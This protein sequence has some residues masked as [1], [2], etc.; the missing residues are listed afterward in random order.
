MSSA[1]DP[2]PPDPP[3]KS[4]HNILISIPRTASNLVTHVLALPSQ[5]SIFAHP[6][7]GYFFLPALSSRFE[8]S[9]FTRPLED[10]SSEER[11]SLEDALGQSASGWVTWMANAETEGKGTYVKEHVNWM[12]KSE[13]ESAFLHSSSKAN[14]KDPP[15]PPPAQGFQEKPENP[16]AVPDAFWKNVQVTLLIHHPALTFPSTLRTAIDNEGLETVL[17]E[18]SES[19]MRWECTFKWHVLLYKFLT[20]LTSPSW[21]EPL[22]IDASQL[23]DG[24]FVRRYAGAVGLDPTLVRT[25]WSAVPSS[26]QSKLHAI[27]RRMRDTLLGSNGIVSSKLS[28]Q[29]V[30]IEAEKDKWRSEF[31][32]VLADRL[33]RLVREAAEGYEWLYERRWRG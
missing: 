28:F 10:W 16:T 5:P 4:Q 17:G 26:E 29:P 9:T 19:V 11:A 7:N 13:I 12:V 21:P 30:D 25:S 33:N 15:S 2:P 6:R 24:G 18:E 8:N 1:T 22:I 27:E 20:S 14:T 23:Q 31:G 32:P 3:S